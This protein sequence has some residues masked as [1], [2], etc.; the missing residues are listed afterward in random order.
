MAFSA[1]QIKH[2]AQNF[3]I[4]GLIKHSVTSQKKSATLLAWMNRRNHV[5]KE[6]GDRNRKYQ[7]WLR[8]VTLWP[9]TLLCATADGPFTRAMTWQTL[10]FSI[11][12]IP[13]WETSSR[14]KSRITK[15]NFQKNSS[16]QRLEDQRSTRISITKLQR[17]SSSWFSRWDN[18]HTALQLNSSKN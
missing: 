6:D 3:C 14:R 5:Y 10:T 15:D 8:Q 7:I 12:H 1:K 18:S 9:P 17:S 11:S 2:E 13:D 16:S 4:W